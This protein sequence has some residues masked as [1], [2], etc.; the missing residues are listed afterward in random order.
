MPFACGR[1]AVQGKVL[2]VPEHC[3]EASCSEDRAC[4]LP[5]CIQT[6]RAQ[7]YIVCSK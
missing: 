3:R 7:G 4:H 2:K 5:A 1:D 6:H